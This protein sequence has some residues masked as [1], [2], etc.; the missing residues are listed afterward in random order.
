VNAPV[1][2]GDVSLHILDDEGILFAESRQELH[3]TNTAATFLWCLLENA[4]PID[5][6]FAAY[7]STFAL[8][9]DEARRH[10]SPI[11]RRWFGLGH[12]SAPDLPNE[13]VTPLAA[14]LAFLLTNDE[15]R[16]SF[17]RSPSVVARALAI[18]PDDLDA[19]V[20]LDPDAL[21]QQAVEIE[22]HR[23]RQRFA[24]VGTCSLDAT[25]LLATAARAAFDAPAER[26]R[27]RLIDTTFT[28]AMPASVAARAVPVLQH[29]EVASG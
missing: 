21:D 5:R 18:E 22:E 24:P 4:L 28:V 15:L 2:A 20:A 1:I 17:R 8:D 12:I 19:F 16:R 6:L 11:L 14:G 26:R 9:E 10:V 13:S 27:Y 25:D 3:S 29:L 7:A 23:R